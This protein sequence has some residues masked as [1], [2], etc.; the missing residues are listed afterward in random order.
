M[1]WVV[2]LVGVAAGMAVAFGRV[3]AERVVSRYYGL[4]PQLLFKHRDILVPFLIIATAA[5]IYA[6]WITVAYGGL[7]AWRLS[8]VLGLV[9]LVAAQIVQIHIALRPSRND[10]YIALIS[11]IVYIYLFALY[12]IALATGGYSLWIF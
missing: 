10:L 1:N 4:H 2:I 9:M 5:N 6:V 3:Y 11:C 7:A 8:A 12:I